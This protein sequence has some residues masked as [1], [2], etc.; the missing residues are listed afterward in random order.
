[1]LPMTSLGCRGLL[2][3]I[4][5]AFLLPTSGCSGTGYGVS[6]DEEKAEQV[7][8]LEGV[9]LADVDWMRTT[10][11][12]LPH[13]VELQEAI[14]PLHRFFS[15]DFPLQVLDS[16]EADAFRSAD[17][18][19]ETLKVRSTET[20]EVI[21]SRD[22]TVEFYQ[23]EA[24]KERLL[25]S[26]C[27]YGH[28][29]TV[30]GRAYLSDPPLVDEFLVVFT[31]IHQEPGWVSGARKTPGSDGPTLL[32]QSHIDQAIRA[33]EELE[34]WEVYDQFQKMS[35]SFYEDENDVDWGIRQIN[36]QWMTA[37]VVPVFF[38]REEQLAMYVHKH[39]GSELLLIF[40]VEE[41]GY[42]RRPDDAVPREIRTK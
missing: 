16:E 20:S 19:P 18:D 9:L 5:T 35:G 37:G 32:Q 2:L 28:L 24:G 1:M 11:G 41:V 23:Q 21:Y 25:L 36:S 4:I 42:F 26:L 33:F 10:V 17:L 34:S 22:L 7:N 14:K 15:E 6:F 29:V 8:L 39:D 31:D 13:Y 30:N 38:T 40:D 27:L 3:L 12:G